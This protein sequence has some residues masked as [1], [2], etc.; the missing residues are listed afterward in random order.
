MRAFAYVYSR[1]KNHDY[2]VLSDLSDAVFPSEIRNSFENRIK[3]VTNDEESWESFKW[4]LVKE[5]GFVLWGV[6]CMNE[7]LDVQYSKDK[8]PRALRGFTGYVIP[9]YSGQP[10]ANDINVFKEI[11]RKVMAP[12]FDSYVQEQSADFLV[13]V[14]SASFI[15]PEPF[16]SKLNTDYHRCRVFS[17]TVDAESL[18]ASCLSYPD[19]ISVAINVA[20]IESVTTPRFNPLM[21]AV[22]R[23]PMSEEITDIPVKHLCSNCGNTVDDLYDGLCQEC[24]EVL[25]PH[26]SRCGKETSELYDG[27]CLD[28]WN[29][30]HPRCK[31]CGKEAIDLFDGLCIDCY[32]L[33]HPHCKKCDME[34]DDPT[35]LSSRGLCKK[36]ERK[37][38]LR[39]WVGIGIVL[40]SLLFTIVRYEKDTGSF[41]FRWPVFERND[42]FKRSDSKA[43]ELPKQQEKRPIEYRQVPHQEERKGVQPNGHGGKSNT[44][45]NTPEQDT[46]KQI[47]DSVPNKLFFI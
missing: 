26:C 11:F 40:L 24:W 32:K 44:H 23:E 29:E 15:Y 22:M 3:G 42:F 33:Q 35:A 31:N 9:N 6:A 20:R 34:F 43:K 37:R 41:Y 30:Q 17:P 27:L 28:C 19:D 25:H 47:K 2:R 46:Q 21:N 36:C 14:N 8:F 5:R 45:H 13:D 39:V 16:N 38:R 12:I 7:M 10:L 1:T 4:V 18:V